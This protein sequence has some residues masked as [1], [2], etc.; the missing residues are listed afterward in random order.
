MHVNREEGEE[1]VLLNPRKKSL[2]RKVEES[3]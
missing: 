1:E 3:R 2:V